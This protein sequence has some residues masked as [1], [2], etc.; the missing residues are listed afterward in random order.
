MMCAAQ[1]AI[2]SDRPRVTK[3]YNFLSEARRDLCFV[4]TDCNR[5]NLRVRRFLEFFS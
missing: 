2:A 4:Y 3:I 1:L 5:S